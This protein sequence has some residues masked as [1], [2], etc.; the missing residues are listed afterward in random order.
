MYIQK[1]TVKYTVYVNINR[2]FIMIINRIFVLFIS[3]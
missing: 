2:L 1:Y 3:V